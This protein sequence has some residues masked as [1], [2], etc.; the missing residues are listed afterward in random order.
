M[1]LVHLLLRVVSWLVPSDSR[2]DW[3]QEWRSEFRYGWA[4]T[5]T[6]YRGTV[7][8]C[9]RCAG[10]FLD[11]LKLRLR[12]RRGPRAALFETTL[13]D[14]RFG[15]RTLSK[16]PLFTTVAVLTLGLGIGAATAMF[17]VVDGVLLK[18]VPFREADQLFNVWQTAEGARGSPGLVGRTWDRLPM[19]FEQ[20]RNWQL[21][22][23][24]FESMAVHNAVQATLTGEGDADQLWLGYGSASLLN[25]LG[26]QTISGRWFLPGEEGPSAGEAAP[27][28]VLSYDTWQNRFGGNP[29]ILQ[30]TLTLNGVDRTIIGVLPPSFRLRYLGMHWLG[31]DRDGKRDVWAPLGTRAL[32]SGNNLEAIGRLPAGV[33]VEQAHAET[34]R[35][36]RAT[37][38]N[39]NIRLV[40]RSGDETHGLSSPLMLLFGATGLL[41]LIAC[42]NIATLSLGELQGRRFELM[43]RSALGAGK[44]RIARQLLTESLLLGIFGSMVG[45]VLAMG[46]TKILIALAPPLPRLGTVGVDLRVFCFAALLGTLTGLVFGIVPAFT[47]IRTAASATMSGSSR[48][49]SVKHGRF[50]RLIITAE[51]ALTVVLLVAG[52][53]LGRSFARLLT[54]DP[55]FDSEGLATVHIALPGDDYETPES[56]SAAYAQIT[57]GLEAIPGVT[58]ATAATRLPF[59]GLTNTTTRRIVG[60]EDEEGISAQQVRVL[61]GYHETMGIPL[62]AGRTLTDADGPDARPVMLISE[63]IARQYFPSESPLGAQVGGWSVGGITIVGIVGNVKRNRLG[64]EADRVFYTSLVQR[65]QSSL[66]LV[67]RTNGAPEGLLTHMRDVVRA[68]D[69]NVPVTEPNTMTALISESA[70][71]ERYRT[72]LMAVFGCLA[73]VLAAVGV[74][75]V[76]ARAVSLRTREYGIRIALGAESKGLKRNILRG[77]IGTG[78]IG[79]VVGLFVAVGVT[80]L[81]SQFLFG[82]LS[83]DPATYGTVALILIA[84]CLLASYIPALR[85]TRVDPVEVLRTE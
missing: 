80:R 46:G 43:T 30:K 16:R 12:F 35:I 17:S 38:E 64:A 59:P 60:R 61:P 65:P 45:A 41:L 76:A 56:A 24:T 26:V 71:E 47:S 79:I 4:T 75:G 50:E 8:A 40:P 25:V 29:E 83:W 21:E 57:A 37:R 10:A 42:G 62:L 48:T 20:Y 7:R 53:L 81:M 67:V 39:T 27:V 78:L 70:S 22:N 66:R 52:G 68:F 69:S 14:V 6:E 15:I 58:A 13:A 82:V 1:R 73:C 74:F 54:V 51:I 5:G 44:R 36:L 2:E 19:S 28:V 63:N 3:L 72:L 18:S 77:S 55:G 9:M 84:V 33:T 34:S 49:S 31:E 11:A 23:T 32:G 85:V